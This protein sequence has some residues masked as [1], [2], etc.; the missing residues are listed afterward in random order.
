MS[1]GVKKTACSEVAAPSHAHMRAGRTQDGHIRN[2]SDQRGVGGR[3]EA[4]P[5][6]S[7]L[8]MNG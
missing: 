3:V 4:D 6:L 2:T 5:G 1:G 7:L 8:M